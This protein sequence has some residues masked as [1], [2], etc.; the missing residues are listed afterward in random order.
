MTY[1]EMIHRTIAHIAAQSDC[2][3]RYKHMLGGEISDIECRANTHWTFNESKRDWN[4]GEKSDSDTTA[5]DVDIEN[6]LSENESVSSYASSEY[7]CTCYDSCIGCEFHYEK[8]C[9]ISTCCLHHCI[10]SKYSPV[11]CITEL[12]DCYCPRQCI[13]EHHKYSR[14]KDNRPNNQGC[15]YPYKIDK[16]GDSVPCKNVQCFWNKKETG[17]PGLS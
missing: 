17:T 10:C 16:M 1:L 6:I 13:A 7:P 14:C 11:F 9:N 12:H 15:S 8:R 2:V 5:S 4:G 3:C